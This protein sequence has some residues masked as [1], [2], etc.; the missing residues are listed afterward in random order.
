MICCGSGGQVAQTRLTPVSCFF[1][2]TLP[3]PS[4]AQIL[5]ILHVT[6]DPKLL[7]L[8]EVPIIR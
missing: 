2:W 7:D 1:V 6:Q 5:T 3:D 8:P 4:N